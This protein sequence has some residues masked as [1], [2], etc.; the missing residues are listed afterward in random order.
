LKTGLVLLVKDGLLH[1]ADFDRFEEKGGTA[2]KGPHGDGVGPK[3]VA[4]LREGEATP[5]HYY[6]VLTFLIIIQMS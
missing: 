5:T 4:G 3:Q 6:R 1:S 2:Y